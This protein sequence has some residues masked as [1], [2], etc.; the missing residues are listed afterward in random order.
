MEIERKGGKSSKQESLRVGGTG[1]RRRGRGDSEFVR[2]GDGVQRRKA[3]ER[4]V[5]GW[6]WWWWGQRDGKCRRMFIS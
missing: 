3:M 6:G 4:V 5:G 1:Q 2:T